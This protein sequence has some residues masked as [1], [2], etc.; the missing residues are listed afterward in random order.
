MKRNACFQC[1]HSNN[2]KKGKKSMENSIILQVRNSL[3]QPLWNNWYIKELLG[4]GSFGAVYRIEAQRMNRTDV[5]A[6]KMELAIEPIHSSTRQNTISLTSTSGVNPSAP[7]T[8]KST[9]FSIFF[10]TLL[11]ITHPQ[12]R[13]HHL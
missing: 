11:S 12:T 4:T 2:K 7:F 6:L 9:M 13:N 1:I 8:M 3:R 10:Q 5:S